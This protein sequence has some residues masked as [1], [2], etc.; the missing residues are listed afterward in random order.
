MGESLFA[1][2]VRQAEMSE[3]QAADKVKDD[4]RFGSELREKDSP[5]VCVCGQEVEA[6]RGGVEEE[7]DRLELHLGHAKST[8]ASL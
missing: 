4:G 1:M 3:T 7:R 5:D 6:A 8:D 2:I